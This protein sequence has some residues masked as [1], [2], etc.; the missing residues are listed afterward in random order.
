[1]CIDFELE[2]NGMEFALASICCTFMFEWNMYKYIDI[3]IKLTVNRKHTSRYC[4]RVCKIV[5]ISNDL[6]AIK[7]FNLIFHNILNNIR[8]IWNA[9]HCFAYVYW[10]IIEMS[11]SIGDAKNDS[12]RQRWGVGEADRIPVVWFCQHNSGIHGPIAQT[13]WESCS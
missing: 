10:Q 8:S 9:M 13:Y 2:W 12:Y 1:M 11:R 4:V 6:F 3:Q 7:S 5:H